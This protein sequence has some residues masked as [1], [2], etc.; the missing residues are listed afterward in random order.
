MSSRAH[1]HPV[2]NINSGCNLLRA[3]HD[4][5]YTHDCCEEKLM[6]PR[7]VNY[8]LRAVDSAINDLEST[9]LD[10][11]HVIFD[12]LVKDPISIVKAIYKQFNW[13]F[14]K[15]YEDILIKFL[16]DD[17]K[18]RVVQFEKAK[19]S[20][21]VNISELSLDKYGLNENDINSK[22]DKYCNDF[23]FPTKK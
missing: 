3:I 10:C 9:K 20:K 7:T 18:K 4:L 17:K 12:E 2:P 22:F 5:Y 23:H 8:C 1:R 6:G 16:D 19:H 15:Q 14:T 13:E 21:Q 11:G